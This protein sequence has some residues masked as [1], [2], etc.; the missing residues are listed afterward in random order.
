[1]IG[2]ATYRLRNAILKLAPDGA[3][4]KLRAA[5]KAGTF[6][7]AGIVF[8]QV[9]KAAGS[10]ISSAVYGQFIG[11][12]SVSDILARCPS[13]VIELPRFSVVRNPWARLVSAWSFAR[14]GSGTGGPK[15]AR[16]ANPEQYQTEDFRSFPSF[17]AHWLSAKDV[18]QLDYV[19][20]P[21]CDFL[22]DQHGEIAVDHL[23]KVENLG[24]TE[25]WL[26][27]KLGKPIT[28][29]S[30][31]RTKHGHYRDYYDP[32]SKAKVA[33]IYR[34]HIELFSYEY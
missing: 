15:Q 1:M 8:V 25:A 26:A 9:P 20:R 4:E 7:R 30:G 34:K 28:F 22:L 19:F 16:I 11:H 32:E 2:E 27:N 6:R 5:R 17:V 23:G 21:Q 10:S 29:Q 18:S 24:E 31:N 12:F 33:E 14:S 13:D 3:M